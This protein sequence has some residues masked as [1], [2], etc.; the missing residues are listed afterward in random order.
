[1][2]AWLFQP[3]EKNCVQTIHHPRGRFKKNLGKSWKI[4]TGT[5][6]AATQPAGKKP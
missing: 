6:D 3:T 5:K 1:L 2:I 4:F